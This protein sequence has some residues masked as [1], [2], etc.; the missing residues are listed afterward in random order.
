MGSALHFLNKVKVKIRN[1]REVEMGG[2]IR[3]K[4]K[5]KRCKLV[6]WRLIGRVYQRFGRLLGDT[7]CPLEASDHEIQVTPS[8][9]IVQSQVHMCRHRTSAW[10]GLTEAG[11]FARPVW[12][13]ERGKEMES[14][15]KGTIRVVIIK[16]KL[17]KERR[18]DSRRLLWEW[19]RAVR[20]SIPLLI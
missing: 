5:R 18:K 2:K 12:Y 8:C 1:K 7:E 10:M 20:L 6:F 17:N 19:K 9:T 13:R 4:E 16:F 3:S 14:I 11:L 15:F